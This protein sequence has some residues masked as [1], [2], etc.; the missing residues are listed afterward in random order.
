MALNAVRD[1]QAEESKDEFVVREPGAIYIFTRVEG[2]SDTVALEQVHHTGPGDPYGEPD[3][4]NILGT[5]D[6]KSRS[7]AVS[8]NIIAELPDWVN[9]GVEVQ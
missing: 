5:G 4:M 6:S 2:A 1:R 9:V 7:L 8:R 3:D